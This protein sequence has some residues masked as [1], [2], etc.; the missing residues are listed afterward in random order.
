MSAI[1]WIL[2]FSSCHGGSELLM[3][4]QQRA[5]S[6]YEML[7]L[8]PSQA[9]FLLSV[10][11]AMFAWIGYFASI[12]FI[13]DHPSYLLTIAFAVLAGGCLLQI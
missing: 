4:A 2:S 6:G 8:R 11:I 7:N 5:R 10:I 9:T 1:M 3:I 13:G 12:P